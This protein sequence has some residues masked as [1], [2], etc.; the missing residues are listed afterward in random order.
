MFDR[1]QA[2]T[3]GAALAAVGPM[4]AN[5]AVAR[6]SGSGPMRI[7]RLGWAGVEIDCDGETLL[8]D[9]V[10]DIAPM[11]PILRSPNEPFPACSRPGRAAGALLTHL[12]ADHADPDALAVALRKGAPVFRPAPAAGTKDD[13]ELTSI[14]ETKFTRHKLAAEIVGVWE[15]REI[16]PFKV[17][18]APAVD[19]FGDPQHSWIVECG[20]RRIIHAGDTLNHGNWWRIAHRFGGFDAA[21]LPI[22]APVCVWPHLQPSSPIEATMTPEEAAVAAHILH[23]KVVVPIHYGSLNKAGSYEETQHPVERL[24]ARTAEYGIGANICQPGDWFTFG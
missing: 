14:G 21:F 4:N 16:G 3:A 23:A 17:F 6:P 7:R 10:Q 12:H 22:N 18:S 19:G 11:A 15:A 5:A 24:Q 20:G 13:V 9:Y 2:I 1:R 8:I